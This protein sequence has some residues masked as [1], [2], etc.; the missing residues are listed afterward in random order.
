MVHC[1]SR[2][3][4]RHIRVLFKY[5]GG[6]FEQSSKKRERNNREHGYK[7]PTCAYVFHSQ[8]KTNC[9]NYLPAYGFCRRGFNEQIYTKVCFLRFLWP[10]SKLLWKMAILDALQYGSW[11]P[12]WKI[13]WTV[14]ETS[15]SAYGKVTSMSQEGL[16]KFSLPYEA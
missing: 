16:W 7:S 6:K 13:R 14:R 12:G 5:I 10:L 9:L 1:P 8:W 4:P 15:E 11:S 3:M 2:R